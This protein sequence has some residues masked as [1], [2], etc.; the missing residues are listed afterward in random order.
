MKKLHIIGQIV[1]AVITLTS[2]TANACTA[3]FMRRGTRPS[4]SAARWIG[5][6]TQNRPMAFPQGMK[7]DAAGQVP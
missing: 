1:C 2:V 4:L 5:W 6:R 7:R 3:S